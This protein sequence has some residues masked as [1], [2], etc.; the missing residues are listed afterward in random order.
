V[1]WMQRPSHPPGPPCFSS[2]RTYECSKESVQSAVPDWP[3]DREQGQLRPEH[4]LP[5]GF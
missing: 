1:C 3:Q 2:I 5:D 4:E